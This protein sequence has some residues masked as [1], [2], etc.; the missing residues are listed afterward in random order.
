M[1]TWQSSAPRG[2][3]VRITRSEGSVTIRLC[4]TK[5]LG[6]AVLVVSEDEANVIA[7]G[8]TA[9]MRHATRPLRCAEG[10]EFEK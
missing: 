6:E 4:E 3:A 1:K 2:A 10:E 7:E 5:H 9:I 8:L